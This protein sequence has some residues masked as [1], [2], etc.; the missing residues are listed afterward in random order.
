ML[1]VECMF[2]WMNFFNYFGGECI[3]L[4]EDKE[5]GVKCFFLI[6]IIEVWELV[7]VKLEIF[8]I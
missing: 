7:S 2:L 6:I 8:W 4:G 3:I 5:I 1:K